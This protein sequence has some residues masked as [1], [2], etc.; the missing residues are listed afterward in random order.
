M[1]NWE[2]RVGKLAPIGSCW[3]LNLN[4]VRSSNV[5]F[6][7]MAPM[8][9]ASRLMSSMYMLAI[10]TL[11][12]TRKSPLPSNVAFQVMAPMT[13]ASRFVSG[14]YMLA[15]RTLAVARKSPD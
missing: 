14:M 13:L 15:T 5:V 8:T 4:S 10:R 9:L 1:G 3:K 2:A 6:L 11:T 7:A 12:V